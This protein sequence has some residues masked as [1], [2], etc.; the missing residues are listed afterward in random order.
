MTTTQVHDSS[1]AGTSRSVTFLHGTRSWPSCRRCGSS[2][3]GRHEAV[4]WS[5]VRGVHYEVD[6]FRCG[7]GR[8]RHVRRAV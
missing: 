4:R 5:T 3:A 6:V 2:L 8:G 1:F 7:C